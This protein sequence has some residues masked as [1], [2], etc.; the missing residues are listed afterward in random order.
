MAIPRRLLRAP[1]PARTA[2]RTRTRDRRPQC[3]PPRARHQELA[4]QP[5]EGRVPPPRARAYFD[6]FLGEAGAEI[7]GVDGSVGTGL[8]GWVDV[9]RRFHGDVDGPYTWWPMRGQAFDNDSGWRIDYHLATPALAERVTAYDVARAAS[10]DQRWS[11][12]APVVVDWTRT[13]DA[14]PFRENPHPRSGQPAGRNAG[15]SVRVEGMRLLRTW[16]GCLIGCLP[17]LALL[18]VPQLMRS[19]A[20]ASSCCWSASA[21]SSCCSP[22]P[23]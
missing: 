5:Q 2:R 23:S 17:L 12:H 1:L 20:G 18:L 9:G 13:P 14:G 15:Q 8:L 10:D 6:R 3:R 16:L 19:R 11:D 21:F 22:L 7:T 4:R